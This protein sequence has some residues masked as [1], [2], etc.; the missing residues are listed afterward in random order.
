LNNSEAVRKISTVVLLI[1][2]N[3]ELSE[4]I[5][6]YGR[7]QSSGVILNIYLSES[8]IL[9]TEFNNETNSQDVFTQFLFQQ[10]FFLFIFI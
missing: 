3:R 4:K 7:Y 1:F 5:S 6:K 10:C 8:S 9:S 2:F